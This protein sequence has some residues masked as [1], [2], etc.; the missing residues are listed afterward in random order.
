VLTDAARIG[1][2][3]ASLA[4]TID[5]VRVSDTIRRNLRSLLAKTAD[6]DSCRITVTPVNFAQIPSGSTIVTTVEVNFADVTWVPC[7]WLG[8]VVLRGSAS[9]KRE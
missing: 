6:A 3:Q 2:R 7:H 8:N 4:T 5:S 9:M 1:C